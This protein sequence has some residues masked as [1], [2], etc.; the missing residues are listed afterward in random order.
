MKF[1]FLFSKYLGIV[2]LFEQGLPTENPDRLFSIKLFV[3]AADPV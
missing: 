1:T 2:S 3:N